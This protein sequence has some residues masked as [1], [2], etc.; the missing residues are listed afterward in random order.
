MGALIFY[1]AHKSPILMVILLSLK[2]RCKQ[3]TALTPAFAEKAL[4]GEAG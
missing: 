4:A 3:Y 1:A 2:L